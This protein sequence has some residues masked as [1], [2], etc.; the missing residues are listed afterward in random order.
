MRQMTKKWV[1]G[2]SVAAALGACALPGFAQTFDPQASDFVMLGASSGPAPIP[3]LPMTL[4]I[5]EFDSSVKSAVTGQALNEVV[6]LGFPTIDTQ[7]ETVTDRVW[8][9]VHDSPTVTRSLVQSTPSDFIFDSQSEPTSPFWLVPTSVQILDL[10]GDGQNDIAFMDQT[11]QAEIVVQPALKFQKSNTSNPANVLGIPG[12]S[13]APFFQTSINLLGS[14]GPDASI[15]NPLSEVSQPVLAVGDFDGDGVSDL[16]FY[17]FVIEG[18]SD[19]DLAAVLKNNG[20]LGLLPRTDTTLTPPAD[21][22]GQNG[23]YNVAAADVNGDGITDLVMTFDVD[24]TTDA[25]DRLLVFLGNGDGTVASEPDVDV[26]VSD[27]GDLH[28]LA[29]GD[30]D[31]NGYLDYALSVTGNQAMVVPSSILQVILCTPGTPTSCN[32]QS[33]DLNAV[34]YSVASED[35]NSD[36]LDDLA[37][38]QLSCASGDCQ[39]GLGIIGNIGV[40]LNKGSSFSNTSDQTLDL[41]GSDDRRLI[42]QVVSKDIDGCGGPDLAYI[43]FAIPEP[44]DPPVVAAPLKFSSLE[45]EVKLGNLNEATSYTSVAFNN[46]E[47]PVADAGEGTLTPGGFLVGGNPTCADPSEDTQSIQWTVVSGSATISNATV[48]NP[49]I[50]NVTGTTVLQVTCTDACGLSDTYTVTLSGGALV[51]GSGCGMS[52]VPASGLSF[53]WLASLLAFLPALALR[54]RSR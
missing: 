8:T 37:L 6:V 24:N 10:N 25:S 31:G 9:I 16:A 49:V 22:A 26:V 29:I 51:E 32:V 41:G 15:P 52:L 23:G 27:G 54:R 5:G 44:S 13:S 43:G 39:N 36:G 4:N 42:L 1:V 35:F 19:T 18:Q 20:T 48:A 47:A 30:F 33:V 17:D 28:G 34:V 50:T 3:A 12:K 46:N 40:Y 11:L 7:A 53:G 14:Q 38:A 45:D 21:V 2:L